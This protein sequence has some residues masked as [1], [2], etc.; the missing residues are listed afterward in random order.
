[1]INSGTYNLQ[2]GATV[3]SRILAVNEYGW[4]E[5]G[6]PNLSGAIVEIVPHKPDDLV[7][8]AQ[9]NEAQ[10]ELEVTH[11]TGV[12]TGGS[13]IIT[14]VIESNGGGASTTYTPIIGSVLTPFLAPTGLYVHQGLS[15]GILYKYK[16][17]AINRQGNGIES[18]V[19]EITAGTAPH[20]VDKP[21][22]TYS[23]L[24]YTISW[25]APNTGGVSI[26]YYIVEIRKKDETFL[27]PSGCAMV[28]SPTVTCDV[29]LADL[30]DPAKF[31]LGDGNSVV[32]ARVSAKNAIGTGEFS[33]LSAS[34]MVYTAP[35]TPSAPIRNE[36]STKVKI[37]VDCAFASTGPET[38][39]LPIV[40][41]LYWN[42]NGTANTTVSLGTETS[43]ELDPT[44]AGQQYQFE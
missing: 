23:S 29:T 19:V 11:L 5:P 14:Y 8:G 34:I 33:E 41:Y 31:D 21:D 15:S 42:G 36:A 16:Y 40:G 1:L 22:V 38:G 20:K 43:Y 7:R 39:G 32:R 26:D 13:D 9:T 44:E 18:D 28:L 35:L 25:D 2:Q 3:Q 30:H 12:E 37:V 17:Y 24:T 10:I 6:V 4:S 27:S